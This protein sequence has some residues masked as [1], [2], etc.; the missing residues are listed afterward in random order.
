M[1]RLSLMFA[2]L[3]ALMAAFALSISLQPEA[4]HAQAQGAYTAQPQAA[5]GSSSTTSTSSCA[6]D[7]SWCA[8]CSAHASISVCLKYAPGNGI[9][10]ATGGVDPSNAGVEG[11]GGGDSGMGGSGGGDSGGGMGG[12]GGDSGGG[13][14]G[15]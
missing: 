4:V 6:T 3:V 12:G 9:A 11:A 2:T 8:Y 1:S 13:M 5:S 15:G 10:S 7:D 14:G